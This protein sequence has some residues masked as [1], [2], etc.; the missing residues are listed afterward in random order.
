MRATQGGAGL[1]NNIRPLLGHVDQI[2]STSVREFNSIHRS[3]RTDHIRHM[4]DRRSTGRTEV[5]NLG[6]GLDV[7]VIETAQNTG[8]ELASER[9]PYTV[10]DFFFFARGRVGSADRDSLFTVDGLARGDVSGDE[11]VFLALREGSATRP[12]VR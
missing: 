10:F 6:S 11:Q 8:G 9:V 12:C 2:T 7:D 4:G 3:L 5:Q 1:T